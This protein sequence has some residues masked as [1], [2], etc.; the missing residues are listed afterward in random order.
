MYKGILFALVAT[1]AGTAAAQT[2][3]K[4][5]PADPKPRTPSVEYRSAF[6]EYRPYSEPELAAWRAANEE[7]AATGGHVGMAR[8][9]GKA[10]DKPEKPAPKPPAHE[11]H[12]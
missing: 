11:G 8:G 5:D 3:A 6:T 9:H 4:P 2:A 10:E 7:V 1:V 12:K